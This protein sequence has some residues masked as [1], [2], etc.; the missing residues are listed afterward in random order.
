MNVLKIVLSRFQV[1]FEELLSYWVDFGVP[2]K[3]LSLY[4]ASLHL[5]ILLVRILDDKK[6]GRV[7]GAFIRLGDLAGNRCPWSVRAQIPR[8]DQ[9]QGLAYVCAK[10]AV[11][12]GHCLRLP[13]LTHTRVREALAFCASLREAAVLLTKNTYVWWLCGWGILK[14]GQCT[15]VWGRCGWWTVQ[16]DNVHCTFDLW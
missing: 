8:R 11:L 14:R 1:K 7:K 6:W 15:S 10:V 16:N 2:W 12:D 13:V 4:T 5:P 3:V 9:W